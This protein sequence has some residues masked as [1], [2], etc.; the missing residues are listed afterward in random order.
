MGTDTWATAK[1]KY[2][3][4]SGGQLYPLNL[5]TTA[6]LTGSRRCDLGDWEGGGCATSPA[7]YQVPRDI[8]G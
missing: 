1:M 6:E 5:F 2:V 4:V 8:R 7:T 3:L